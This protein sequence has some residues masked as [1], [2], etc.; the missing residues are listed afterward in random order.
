LSIDNLIKI[1]VL[2]EEPFSQQ[3]IDDL[4]QIVERDLNDSANTELSYDWQFGIAY[5]AALKLANILVRMSGYRVK[6]QSHHMYTFAMIPKIL[7]LDKKADAD[8][9][10]T[11]RRKR[12]TVEYDYVGG[13]S[14][15]DV[16]E[17]RKFTIEFKMIVEKWSSQKNKTK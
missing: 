5:N 16:E 4:F 8:Y 14:K 15:E 13:A 7:G 9:L 3:E 1:G 17:L 12:N 6:G 10:D 2:E 11:C